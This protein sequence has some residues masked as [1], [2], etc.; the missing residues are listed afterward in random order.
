MKLLVPFDALV[1]Q[2]KNTTVLMECL[3]SETEDVIL[4]SLKAFEKNEPSMHV[5]EVDEG[6]DTEYYSYKQYASFSFEDVV[7]T[8]TVSLP[9]CFRRSSFL[10]I[11]SMLE[12]HLTNFCNK[13]M[14]AMRFPLSYKD[15]NGTGIERCNTILK[16]SSEW[17]TPK[18]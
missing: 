16:K 18:I 3:V 4:H 5:I 12:F 1:F 17:F 6:P 13:K 7:D 15:I 9:S 14:D 10:T 11:Y 8:Y 2:L